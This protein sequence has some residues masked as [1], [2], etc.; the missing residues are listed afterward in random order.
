MPGAKR[1]GIAHGPRP[2]EVHHEKCARN[3]SLNQERPSPT[4]DAL[5]ERSATE[6]CEA[7]RFCHMTWP[8]FGP[9]RAA[10]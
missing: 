5:N 1:R 4:R 2:P 6:H 7:M 10:S 9:K 8:C 3:I